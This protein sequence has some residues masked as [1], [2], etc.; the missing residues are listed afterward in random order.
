MRLNLEITQYEAQKDA[1]RQKA[2]SFAAERGK[3]A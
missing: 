2:I 1:I 3:L